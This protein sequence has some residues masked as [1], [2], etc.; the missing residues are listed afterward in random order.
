MHEH[1]HT[2]LFITSNCGTPFFCHFKVVHTKAIGFVDMFEI[3][4]C[5]RK[6][7]KNQ[8]EKRIFIFFFLYFRISNI[9]W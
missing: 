4:I 3:L 6:K 9:C 1:I 2:T 8:K 7:K 5:K